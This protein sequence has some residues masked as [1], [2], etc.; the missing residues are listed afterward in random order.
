MGYRSEVAIAIC[1]TK[2]EKFVG[3]LNEEG[4]GLLAM[5]NKLIMEDHVVYHW[6]WIKWYDSYTEVISIEEAFE[7]VGGAYKEMLRIGENMSDIEDK[8]ER[9]QAEEYWIT[10]SSPEIRLNG[11]EVHG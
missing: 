1:N 8:R 6:D 10:Y 2:V 7:Q 5:S 3:L 9:L 4:Q 11:N